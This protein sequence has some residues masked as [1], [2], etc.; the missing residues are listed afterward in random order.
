MVRFK[1][2]D[3]WRYWIC[4]GIWGGVWR[5]RERWVRERERKV[6]ERERSGGKE[7]EVSERERSSPG[8]TK[9]RKNRRTLTRLSK[10]PG[11]A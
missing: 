7:R 9:E 6:G 1:I 10:G 3:L 4:L 8:K 5:G 11:R 2:W